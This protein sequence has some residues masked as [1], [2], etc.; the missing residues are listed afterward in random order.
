MTDRFSPFPSATAAYAAP[1]VAA[2]QQRRSP[3]EIYGILFER[4]QVLRLFSD[5]KTFADATPKTD[6]DRILADFRRDDPQTPDALRA[7]VTARFDLPASPAIVAVP[8]GDRPELGAYITGLWDRLERPADVEQPGSSLL[9]LPEAYVVP[10]GRF[11][12]IYYWDSYFTMLGLAEDG[13][14]LLVDAM[15]HNFESLIEDYGHVPNGTRT[16][17]LSRSQPPFLALMADLASPDAAVEACLLRAL[18]RE[19][20]YWMDRNNGTQGS[21]VRLPNGAVLNRYWDDLDAPRDESFAEDVATAEASGRPV[22]EVYRDLRAG[23]ASGWDFSSR[24]LGDPDVF[25]SIRTTAILPVDLNS[26]LWALETA[27]A[28]RSQAA[29]QGAQA[30]T[31]RA[32]ADRRA[33]A[34]HAHMWLDGEGRFADV[35]HREGRATSVLSAAT[36]YPLFVGLA[37]QAQADAVAVTVREHLLAAGGVRT[38][39]VATDQQWD[40]PN[41]WA[42]LQWIAVMGLARY[43]HD[44]LAR[45]I[46]ARWLKTVRTAYGETGRLLE[47]Y[48][49]EALKAGGGGEYPVQEGFGWTNGVTRALM[50]RYPELNA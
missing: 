19:H 22:A 5:G 33:A 27:I 18:K 3:R 8:A 39:T 24:W 26:L 45:D 7:F 23:A 9:A 43:G 31:W 41:G 42:P 6:P 17:Y 28:R 10:G 29:G 44:D 21:A 16:Y 46:A 38:T 30:E 47:K 13:R 20:A 2:T 14:G 50:A 11:R 15:L 37:T 49:I 1:Q 32:L 48:D 35:D 34:M 40:M 36:L 25:T 12:E 4:V